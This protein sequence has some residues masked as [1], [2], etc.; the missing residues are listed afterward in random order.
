MHYNLI[1]DEVIENCIREIRESKGKTVKIL[2][3]KRTA[4]QND[5]IHP[6]VRDI[7]KETGHGEEELK[8]HLKIEWVGFVPFMHKGKREMILESTSEYS[9]EKASNFIDRLYA[10]GNQLNIRMKPPSYYGF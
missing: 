3:G 10:L 1:N 2:A 4:K 5:L 9:K 6:L 7:A 8:T